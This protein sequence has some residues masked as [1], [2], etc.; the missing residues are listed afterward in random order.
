[1]AIV[2][3]SIVALADAAAAQAEGVEQ[4]SGEVVITSPLIGRAFSQPFILLTD[5][6]AFVER[7]LLMPLPSPV[8]VTGNL[9]GELSDGA[10]FTIPLPQRP[11]GQA[12]D[13]DRDGEGGVQLYA[14]DFQ[15]N[16]VGDPFLGPLEMQGW[17]TAITSLRVETG[18]NEVVGGRLLAWSPD[19]AE[20]FPVGFGADG[21]LF[22]DDDPLEPLAS[23]WTVI[24]LNRE[25][26]VRIRDAA[27]EVPII[28]GDLELNDLSDRPTRRRS[29]P[30]STSCGD[31]T[32]SPHTRGSTG[33]PCRRSS[34]RWSRRPRRPAMPR[35][36]TSR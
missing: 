30:W 22:T 29:P 6:T 9:E 11:L 20:Q 4:V 19:D 21:L 27:V 33:T 15:I 16:L 10:S 8:Q 17:P 36:S 5:L 28:E 34:D 24:D 32:P 31:A 2:L 35:R 23:G 13:L 26:F 25:P 1:M 3:P 14:V 12:N 18:T 7:D